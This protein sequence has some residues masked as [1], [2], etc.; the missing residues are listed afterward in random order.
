[1]TS[2]HPMD[3]HE[4]AEAH[5][6]TDEAFERLLGLL[7]SAERSR[8]DELAKRLDDPG[9]RAE[10]IGRILPEAVLHGAQS[11]EALAS[12]LRPVVEEILRKAAERDPKEF[13]RVMAPI[14]SAGIGR[15]VKRWLLG[16]FRLLHPILEHRLFSSRTSKWL[17]TPGKRTLIGIKVGAAILAVSLICWAATEGLARYRWSGY[18]ARLKTIPGIMLVS[19]ERNGG[20]YYLTGFKGTH[21]ANPVML[22]AEFGIAPGDVVGRWAPIGSSEPRVAPI[23]LR[24]A[25][26]A[27][28]SV[29]LELLSGTLKA[30][31]SAPLQW[32]LPARRMALLIPG[33]TRYDDSALSIDYKQALHEIGVRLAAPESV[34]LTMEN[35]T[36]KA[37]GAAPYS[38]VMET[39][40]IARLLPGVTAYD[41]S[42]L[43]VDYSASLEEARR[44]LSPPEGVELNMKNGVLEASGLAS[45]EWIDTARKVARLIPG[46]EAYRYSS[47]R[48]DYAELAR[49]LDKR[50]SA[51]P[52]VNLTVDDGMLYATGGASHKWIQEARLVTR[53]FLEISGYDD[54][55][56]ID[57][58]LKRFGELKRKLENMALLFKKD[59]P[60]LLPGQEDSA[61]DLAACAL[62]LQ[63]LSGTVDNRFILDV[64]GRQAAEES[65]TNNRALSDERARR[66]GEYLERQGLEKRHLTISDIGADDP[67]GNADRRDGEGN[68][69]VT[70]RVI[71]PGKPPVLNSSVEAQ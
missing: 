2:L 41:D 25:L 59:S 5:R 18:V 19:A 48:Q 12:A 56:L 39:R 50:L 35:D 63:W 10:E 6:P 61:K 4:P 47:L 42:R 38:W 51:P 15:S 36:L 17:R 8:I 46:V 3:K 37:T 31:G 52:S 66:V 7:L 26:D 60:A 33:V 21:S 70:F 45:A 20:K 71:E 14:I 16:P 30:S 62:E 53:S 49:T 11:N 65:R 1:M 22:A 44:L 57:L 54:S 69:K 23:D 40:K 9:V 34:T 27:P 32:A 43:Q 67:Q 58:D 28:E 68:S 64:I 55:E 29:T 13:G 24:K